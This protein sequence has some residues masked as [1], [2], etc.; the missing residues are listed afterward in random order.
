VIRRTIVD[1]E[2]PP[3]ELWKAILGN[4]SPSPSTPLQFVRL[5]D[6]ATILVVMTLVA[7]TKP[8]YYG[9]LMPT[10]TVEPAEVFNTLGQ[11]AE[12]LKKRRAE[13]G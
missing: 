12:S 11:A 2:N 6:G 5:K 9:T 8:Y 10:A 4:I 13:I 3:D 1:Y 7:G